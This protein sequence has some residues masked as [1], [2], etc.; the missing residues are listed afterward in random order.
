MKRAE[1][2]NRLRAHL[3]ALRAQG[4]RG[5]ALFG[6]TARDE[7]RA[8]SDIDLFLD[9]DFEAQPRFSLFDL[10]RIQIALQ[11]DLGVPV[12]PITSYGRFPRM[13]ANIERDLVPII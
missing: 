8:D 6:S 11:D 13:R 1:A 12:Q 4:V 7:A 9:I 3:P 2:I 10:A 5:M